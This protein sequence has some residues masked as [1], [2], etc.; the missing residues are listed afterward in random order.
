MNF[1]FLYHET[2]KLGRILLEPSVFGR[3]QLNSEVSRPCR[4]SFSIPNR[5][6]LLFLEVFVGSNS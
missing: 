3:Q 5:M 1:S 6:S 2:R 4:R